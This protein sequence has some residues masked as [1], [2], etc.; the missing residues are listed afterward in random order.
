[1][2]CRWNDTAEVPEVAI[3]RC[4][5]LLARW[6]VS[7][8]SHERSHVIAGPMLDKLAVH[9]AVDGDAGQLDHLPSRRLPQQFTA[10]RAAATQPGQNLVTHGDL[11]LDLVLGVGE[12]H[13]EDLTGATHTGPAARQIRERRAVV[14][15]IWRAQ[16][17]EDGAI[18]HIE[19]VHPAYRRAPGGAAEAV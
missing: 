10:E 16:L 2:G 8:L 18:T 5:R 12:G 19:G 17:I 11:F 9:E 6:C 15:V 4:C 13:P 1:M 7:Q 14:T 3:D